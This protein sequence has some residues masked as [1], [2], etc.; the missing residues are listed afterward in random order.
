MFSKR[1]DPKNYFVPGMVLLVALALGFI[2]FMSLDS[3]SSANPAFMAY[4]PKPGPTALNVDNPQNLKEAEAYAYGASN[5]GPTAGQDL[6]RNR[7]ELEDYLAR[8][9]QLEKAA[10]EKY[11][12][13]PLVIPTLPADNSTPDSNPLPPILP[14]QPTSRPGLNSNFAALNGDWRNW[15]ITRGEPT[16]AAI[17]RWLAKYN[18]PHLKEALPGE[19]IGQT[20]LRM[21]RQYGINPAYALAFF[22]KESSC[23]TNGSNLGAHNFGNLRW[24]EGF[25]S[26]DKVWRAYPDWTTG[27]EAWFYLLKEYYINDLGKLTVDEI[28]PV[29][30]PSSENDTQLYINQVKLWVSEIMAG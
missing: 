6:A 2:L 20:Y 23:G 4:A 7:S 9:R 26:L 5:P 12:P 28:L 13:A 22:T 11:S 21:G 30:A 1:T 27:M 24:R 8:V 17:D 18:S 29:Y 15:D 19:T 14:G 10:Q 25:P 3:S 16:A